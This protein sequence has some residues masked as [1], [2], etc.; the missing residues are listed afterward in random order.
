LT[1][2]EGLSCNVVVFFVLECNC[3]YINNWVTCVPKT[4][5]LISKGTCMCIMLFL[6]E[7]PICHGDGNRK[8]HKQFE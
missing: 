1:N 5:C 6:S 8:W 7:S 2:N 3:L 4:K